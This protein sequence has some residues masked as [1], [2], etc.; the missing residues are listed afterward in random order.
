RFWGKRL[1]SH[2]RV[3][4]SL[5]LTLRC[6]R[7][8]ADD[9]HVEVLSAKPTAR[10]VLQVCRR[11][12]RDLCDA[13][14]GRARIGAPRFERKILCEFTGAVDGRLHLPSESRLSAHQLV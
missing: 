1:A 4:Q 13:L 11:K 10:D 14:G 7:L 2:E 3:D 8:V 9:H 5:K 6:L 12:R